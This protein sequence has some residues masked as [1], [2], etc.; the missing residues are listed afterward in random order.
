MRATRTPTQTPTGANGSKI[1][2]ACELILAKHV[3]LTP[4]SRQDLWAQYLGNY[5]GFRITWSELWS[6]FRLA[7]SLGSLIRVHQLLKER[8]WRMA[9]R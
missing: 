7:P 5:Y 4:Q 3:D 2:L 6:F 9:G 1:K 8:G